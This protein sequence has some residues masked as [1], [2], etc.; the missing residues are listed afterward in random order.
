MR[1]GWRCGSR[2]SAAARAINPDYVFSAAAHRARQGR[3]DFSMRAT[4]ALALLLAAPAAAQSGGAPFT[5][6]E[7]G[8]GFGSLGDVGGLVSAQLGILQR[9][10]HSVESA[11][12]AP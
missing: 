6:A 8:R 12:R 9:V 1:D 3:K 10:Q 5:V 2:V 7:S 11:C 4:I